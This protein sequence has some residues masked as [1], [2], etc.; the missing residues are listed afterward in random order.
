[1][2]FYMTNDDALLCYK[3]QKQKV[4]E[5]SNKFK[6]TTILYIIKLFGYVNKPEVQSKR[7]T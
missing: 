1:M 6:W 2:T 4:D 7:V 5:M 3:W